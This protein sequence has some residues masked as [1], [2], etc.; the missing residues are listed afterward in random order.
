MRT[1]HGTQYPSDDVPKPTACG[2]IRPSHAFLKLPQTD[3]VAEKV[4]HTLEEQII[5]RRIR[6]HLKEPRNAVR[7]VVE[8]HTTRRLVEK[9]G[10]PIRAQAGQE[11]HAAMSLGPAT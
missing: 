5:H 9:N 1:D 11:G 2:G 6:R 7:E 8:S 4:S 10:Y 3:G